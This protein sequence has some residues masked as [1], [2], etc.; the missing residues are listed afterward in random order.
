M[1][2]N[3]M[4]NYEKDKSYDLFKKAYKHDAEQYVAKKLHNFVDFFYVKT[5]CF[6]QKNTF[7]KSFYDYE[8]I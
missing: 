3:I 8:T 5:K 1:I 4:S 2:E 7:L 6:S